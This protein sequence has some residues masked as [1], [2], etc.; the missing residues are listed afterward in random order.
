MVNL[1]EGK[2]KSREGTVVDAD[3][4]IAELE[5]LAAEEIRAKERE[6]AVG[7]V[8]ET[9][10]SIAVG[11]LHYYLLQVN[12]GKDMIFNPRE[13]LSFTGNTGPYLQYMCARISSML[14]KAEERGIVVGAESAAD[15]PDWSALEVDEEWLLAR[16]VD[17]FPGTVEQAAR[18]L[19]PALVASHLY[20]LAKTFSGYYH[21]HP[22]L[23]ARDETVRL[24]RLHLTA[25][26]LQALKSGLR[27]LNIPFLS[28]M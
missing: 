28:V 15:G 19:N 10:H 2:M 25:A 4:L 20:D 18:D 8:E 17:G 24:A 1:P 12:P 7:D 11:A 14:R 26:V 5:Q 22:I 21:D 6:D 9:A 16:L 23:A 13:S 27:L 3:D